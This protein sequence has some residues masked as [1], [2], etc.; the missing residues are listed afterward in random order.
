[1]SF[2]LSRKGYDKREVERFLDQVADEVEA[3]GDRLPNRPRGDASEITIARRRADSIVKAAEEK[4]SRLLESAE[5]DRRRAA[6]ALELADQASGSQAAAAVVAPEAAVGRSAAAAAEEGRQITDAARRSAAGIMSQANR[7]ARQIREQAL[8]DANLVAE[9]ARADSDRQRA[10]AG[11][12][13]R[14]TI[15][16]GRREAIRMLEEARV[17]AEI[18]RVTGG[19]RR[20]QPAPAIPASSVAPAAKP[21][22]VPVAA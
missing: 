18:A 4:A 2:P 9:R 8:A 7:D 11:E 14:N 6:A 22:P 19:A 16:M 17:R 13:A 21:A 20:L 15:E 5:R 10:G 12:Q 1:M 3:S